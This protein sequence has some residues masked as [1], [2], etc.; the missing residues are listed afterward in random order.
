M[1]IYT[2]K[3]GNFTIAASA[4][5]ELVDWTVNATI[6]VADTTPVGVTWAENTEL[7]KN[8]TMS[9]SCNYDPDDTVMVALISAY[10]SGPALMT[11]LHCYGDAT[12]NYGGSGIIT[13]ATITKSVGSVDKFTATFQ[14]TGALGYTSS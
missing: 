6:N 1:A 10:V 9:I 2:H 4:I 8:W 5:S 3:A 12:G 14:G 7:G 11:S 13:S